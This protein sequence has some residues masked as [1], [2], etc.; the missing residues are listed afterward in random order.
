MH[1]QRQ[2]RARA[3]LQKVDRATVLQQWEALAVSDAGKGSR[4]RALQ[5]KDQPR[6]QVLFELHDMGDILQ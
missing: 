1:W 4:V 5:G 3:V 2:I 6:I